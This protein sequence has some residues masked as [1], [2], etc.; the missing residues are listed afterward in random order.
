M[1]AVIDVKSPSLKDRFYLYR[2]LVLHRME[3]A[4]KADQAYW[5]ILGTPPARKSSRRKRYV[6]RARKQ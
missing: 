3:E 4:H 1:P 5:G 2:W 6:R